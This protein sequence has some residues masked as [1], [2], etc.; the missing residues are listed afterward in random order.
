MLWSFFKRIRVSSKISSALYFLSNLIETY[1]TYRPLYRRHLYLYLLFEVTAR[2]VWKF[3]Q[4]FNNKFN[5]E[6]SKLIICGDSP[7]SIEF[8]GRVIPACTSETHVGNLLGTDKEIKHNMICDACNDMYS[9]LNLLMQQFKSLDRTILYKLFNNF[10]LS[11][12]GP[13]GMHQKDA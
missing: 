4:D 1:R 8:Q 2:N 10:C 9:Q 11:V 3:S 5:A 12:Y 6:K 7:V 13:W